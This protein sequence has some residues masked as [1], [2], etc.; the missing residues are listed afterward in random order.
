MAEIK[1]LDKS[2]KDDFIQLFSEDYFDAVENFNEEFDD[3]VERG[4]CYVLILDGELIGFFDYIKDYSHYANYLQGIAVIP[5]YRKKGYSYK[6][7]DKFIELSRK[8]KTKNRIALS[9]TT[10]DNIASKKMHE[11]YG[12][13]KIGVLQGLHYGINEIFYAYD[14]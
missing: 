14:L 12:F 8:D 7:L 10:V 13:K 11:S 1:C 2:M 6:L 5:K 9:S 3:L 4:N